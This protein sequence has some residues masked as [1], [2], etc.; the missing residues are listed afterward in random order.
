MK[1]HTHPQ[2]LLDVWHAVQIVRPAQVLHK[3]SVQA[4]TKNLNWR[5]SMSQAIH[6]REHVGSTF[7]KIFRESNARNAPSVV[8]RAEV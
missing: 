5:T 7:S 6:A 3:L 8:R 4:V 1:E 2:I